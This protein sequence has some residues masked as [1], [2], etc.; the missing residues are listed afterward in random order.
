MNKKFFT[1]ILIVCFFLS[2]VSYGQLSDN[3]SVK[4]EITV[5][6]GNKLITA[7]VRTVTVSFSRSSNNVT[8]TDGTE[9]KTETKNYY[10]SLDFEKQDLTFLK[11]FMKN[12][13]GIDGQVTMVDSDGKL[14]S[15]KLEF[16]KATIE[17]LTDQL[18]SDYNS[19]YLSIGCASLIIDGVSLE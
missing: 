14:P 19:S 4:I 2:G 9:K 18:N 17:S 13:T 5:K 10:F 16:T 11:A 7:P 15:R 1:L 8:A 12:K 3:K 6:D